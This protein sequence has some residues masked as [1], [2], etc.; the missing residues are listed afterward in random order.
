MGKQNKI[1]LEKAIEYYCTHPDGIQVCA[2]K[3]H[4]GPGTLQNKLKEKNIKKPEYIVAIGK[5]V[6]KYQTC[7]ISIP[8]CE[9]MYNIPDGK[10]KFYIESENIVR[11]IKDNE[12][13]Y[14]RNLEDAV[15][16]FKNDDNISITDCA[17]KFKIERISLREEL[18]RRKIKAHS[19]IKTNS[20]N[21]KSLIVIHKKNNHTVD[22]DFFSKIDTNQ[23]AYWL[24]FITAD[25]SVDDKN[26]RVGI[27]LSIRDYDQLHRFKKAL[28]TNYSIC[29]T[30]SKLN[31]LNKEYRSCSI[32]I[33]SSKMVYDLKKLGVLPK[34]TKKEKPCKKVPK[35]F[36][37]DY[38]RGF[39]DG[40]GWISAIKRRKIDRCKN[41]RWELG[42]CG[43][44]EMMQ[45]IKNYIEEEIE[46]SF[47]EIL[48]AGP[49]FKIRIINQLDIITIGK[50]LYHD[51]NEYLPRKY[52]KIADLCRLHSTSIEE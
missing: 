36:M 38:I 18:K 19:I 43:S 25:G 5:A 24:G 14:K 29:E 22:D 12:V 37:R 51:A 23:K 47:S 15:Q 6:K 1:G 26:N 9:M 4:I 17:K 44:L 27:G 33:N 20:G 30:V 45:W 35:K 42:F 32:T 49:I 40:D 52:E 41:K 31:T 3:F 34:K 21:R 16:Y 10:L 13:E 50:F 28:R 39:F 8:E 7:F 2:A 11:L 46:V 48:T